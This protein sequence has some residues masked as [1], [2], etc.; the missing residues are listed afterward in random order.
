MLGIEGAPSDCPFGAAH[1]P[2]TRPLSVTTFECFIEA[3]Q[4]GEQ[5]SEGVIVGVEH[6]G[7]ILPKSN[8]RSLSSGSPCG[9]DGVKDVNIGKGELSTV[10]L[11]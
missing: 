7:N 6:S 3:S 2:T 9:V 1:H 4:S 8:S 11:Q 10:V 5:T